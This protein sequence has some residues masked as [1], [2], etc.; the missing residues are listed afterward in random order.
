MNSKQIYKKPTCFKDML[1]LQEALDNKLKSNNRT[2]QQI[3]LSMVAEVIEFNEELECSHKTW[4]TKINHSIEKQKEEIVDVL[5]FYLQLINYKKREKG[6][7]KIDSYCRLFDTIDNDKI[8]SVT[9][10]NDSLLELI[11]NVTFSDCYSIGY[12]IIANINYFEISQDELYELYF[13]KWNENYFDR[14]EKKIEEG[15][16][17]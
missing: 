14:A 16:W 4:K 1:E 5:F 11:Y 7:Y 6:T 17:N 13:K 3:L 8:F 9:N 10:H 12:N 2:E 15:G